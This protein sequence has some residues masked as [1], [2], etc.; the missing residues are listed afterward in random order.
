MFHGCKRMAPKMTL[1][2][3]QIYYED[4]QKAAIY[5]FATAH[6]NETLTDYFENDIIARLVPNINDDLIGICSWRLAEKRLSRLRLLDKTLSRENILSADF[7]VAILTPYSKTHQPLAMARQWH[8]EP[9]VNAEKAL[10]KFIS[11]GDEITHAIYENHF[12]T[13]REIYQDYVINCLIPCMEFMKHN[14][15]F[16]KDGGYVKRKKPEEVKRVV[17]QLGHPWTIAPFI[18]ERLFSIWIDRKKFKVINL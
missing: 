6:K 17:E 11:F 5:P 4:H 10:R 13:R 7:D 16:A 18:L 2:F 12:I 15:V 14:P 9:W 1:S 8:G 3:T